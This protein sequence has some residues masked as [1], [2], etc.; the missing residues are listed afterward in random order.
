MTERT[1]DTDQLIDRI[2]GEIRGQKLDENDVQSATNRV[3]QRLR[4]EG[5]VRPLFSSCEDFRAQIPAYVAGTLPEA[6]A[7]LVGDHTREC[8]PCRRAL[9]EARGA[10]APAVARKSSTT[11]LP[12]MVRTLMRAAAALLL[13]SAGVVGVRTVGNL[14]ADRSLNAS[15]QAIDGDLQLVAGEE[16]RNLE[17]GSR[18]LAHQ[19]LRTAKDSG[20]FLRLADGSVVE[21]D[22]RSE[23]SL[24]ASRSGTTVDLRRGNII[25]HAAEQHGGR[26]FVE[27][28]DCQVAVKGTI[29]AVNHGINGSRVSVIEGIVEVREGGSDSLLHSGDQLSTGDRLRPVPLEDEIAWSRDAAEHRVLLREF[30]GLRR[31]VAGAVDHAPPRTS[32]HLLDLAPGDTFV[33]AAMPNITGDLEAARAALS[34]HLAAS[35]VLA[36]WWQQNVVDQGIDQEIDDL[37]DRLQ[38]IGEA[39]GE[40][41]AIA[42]PTSAIGGQTGLLFLADLDDPD[43]FRVLLAEAVDRAN[44][45]AGA[46]V[47]VIV[48]DPRTA[49]STEAEVL[50]WVEDDL[51]AGA[52]DLAALAALA[53]RIDDAAARDFVGSALHS[54]LDAFYAGGVSWLLGVDIAGATENALTEVDPAEIETMERLGLLDAT[55]LVIERHRDGEWYATDA[56]VLFSGPRRGIASWLA[57]PAP[58]GSLEFVSGQAYIAASAVTKDATGMFDD[59]LPVIS[60]NNPMFLPILR[61]FETELGIDL[62]EDFAASLGGEATIALDGPMLPVPSWKLIVEIY[63]PETFIHA[64]GRAVTEINVLMTSRGEGGVTLESEDLGGRTFYTLKLVDRGFEIVFATVDGYLLVAPSSALIEQAIQYRATGVNLPNS[65]AFRALLPDSGWTDCSALVYRDL[66]SL[67]DALPTEMIEEFGVSEV[68]QDGLSTGLVSVFGGDDRVTVSATGGSLLGLVSTLGMQSAMTPGKEHFDIEK[69]SE[70][71]SSLG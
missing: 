60:D 63:D 24:G 48:D 66:D 57:A 64:L 13:I 9:M 6:R 29:F 28:R 39:F 4:E 34:E 67:V 23:L 38:P 53:A 50:L 70:P 18:I 21:M 58:M 26:L 54:R 51:F 10:L 56:E 33:F 45:E 3:W 32:T 37:L 36:E 43:S 41:A 35:E 30:S 11:G 62:R 22:A 46:T 31:A 5:K 55:T 1:Q 52:H 68:L 12:T 25:V 15:V 65:P 19:I 2:S 47:A 49:G 16:S 44:T 42:V 8:V 17:P 27:T 40:E 59:V 20:A 61:A 7:L 14:I 71:V 69:K